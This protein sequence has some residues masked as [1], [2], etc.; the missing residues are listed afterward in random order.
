MKRARGG[1]RRRAQQ[2]YQQLLWGEVGCVVEH[3]LLW[4]GTGGYSHGPLGA[5][6]PEQCH[7]LRAWLIE[8]TKSRE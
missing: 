4:W 5:E 2:Y 3:V 6:P 8:L 7:H 1:V